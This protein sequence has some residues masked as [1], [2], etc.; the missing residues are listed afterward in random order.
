MQRLANTSPLLER[1]NKMLSP[2]IHQKAAQ[3]VEGTGKKLPYFDRLQKA[4][5]DHDLS[6]VR[7]YTGS[8]AVNAA[9]AIGAKA[10][11]TGN[12]IAFADANPDLH[13]TAHEVTHVIQ[14][15]KGVYLKDGLGQFNDSYEKHAD[16]V[17]DKIVQRQSTE[18]LLS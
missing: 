2:T 16:A 15:R 3:G 10:Y 5:G 12:K 7:A 11:A 14:Q 13:T 8:Q 6:H 17:A 18:K 9:K 1:R 4:F